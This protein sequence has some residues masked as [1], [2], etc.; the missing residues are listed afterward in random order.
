MKPDTPSQYPKHIPSAD[1]MSVPCC[2]KKN[3][4]KTSETLK[5]S[6]AIISWHFKALQMSIHPEFKGHR[7]YS[8]IEKKIVESACAASNIH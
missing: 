1:P 4:K 2:C 3:A 8:N 5:T 7:F 6:F